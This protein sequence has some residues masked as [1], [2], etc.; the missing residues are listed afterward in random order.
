MQTLLQDLRYGARMLLKKPGFTLI[1]V[2]TLA[3]GIG[4]NTA[5]FSVVK[6]VLLASLPY[7]DADQLV[8]LWEND[9]L[10]G[11][12]RNSV[13]PG[14]FGDWRKQNEVC[15]ELACYAQPESVNVTGNG[16]PERL[17]GIGVS[18]NIFAL[19]GTQPML[20][21]TFLPIDGKTNDGRELILSY[22]LWQRRYGGEAG[23]IGKTL[24]FDG[25]PYTIVG[26]MLPQFQLPEEAEMW[27]QT[28]NGELAMRGGYFLRAMGRL[29][30]GV[31]VAQAQASFTTIAR[32]L[33]QQYPDTNKGRG[34]SVVSFRDQFVGDVRRSLLVLF[35]AVGFVLLIA[36]SNVANLL[37]VRAAARGQEMAVRMALGAGRRRLLRQLLTESIMLA[38]AGGALGLLVALWSVDLLT[39]LSP[40]KIMQVQKIKI[41][42]GVLGFTFLTT[43]L[44]GILCGFAPAWQASQT[45]PHD[46]LKEGGRNAADDRR[47]RRVRDLLVVSEIAL[48][49][50]LLVGAGL[51]IKSFQRLQ[52]VEPGIDPRNLLT[53]QFSLTGIKYDDSTQISGGYR[54]LMERLAVVPGV[55]AVAGVSRLPLAGDRSTSGLTIEG[56][57]AEKPEV[58]YRV[59][60]PGYFSLTGI[61][62]RSGR[63]FTERDA[64]GQPGVVV[65]N[66]TLARRYWPNENV[67]GK[68]LK[69]GPN[70]NAPWLTIVGVTG[71]ARNFGL[72][73]E[74][75]PE[76]YVS[77]QQSPAERM[78]LV[79][80]T[81]TE[82][83]SLIPS[84]RAAVQ[85]FDRDLPFSQAATMEQ[86]YAK[87]VAHRRLNMFLLAIFA[88]VALLLAIVGIYGVMSYAVTQRTHEIGV[89]VALGAQANDILKLVIGQG[90]KSVLTGVTVGLIA[91]FGLTRLMKSLLYE[92]APTD[93]VTF[94]GVAFLLAIVALLAC[95][96]PARRATK[97]D[98]MVALRCE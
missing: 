96:V 68:R 57:T 24:T 9:T 18:A 32:R 73:E 63:G 3:L 19:L 67:L 91:A 98:P 59:A 72:D 65:V 74:A 93:P 62:L 54:Q 11:N 43:L 7:R 27:W 6:S 89:R 97:V 45:K 86:L 47:R 51:L 35:G 56:R 12:A 14:N 78:R 31:T 55:Q 52:A 60:T 79:I 8:M 83:L 23:A 64:E 41:D 87:S 20:G 34:I 77:Y 49:L 15:S 38:L 40:A 37:L 94:A 66:E 10:E 69:L 71:D 33:E 92:V 95:Y 82:P 25:V 17:V 75:R 2:I 13:A 85:A 36:C 16:E 42:G 29:K 39:A 26:V 22:G 1:A 53:M 48:A 70:A 80:R 46:T 61:P 76:A 30:P 44:T 90:M 58:H 4:A 88:A 84:V 81:A 21:R 50:V 28:L 5:I